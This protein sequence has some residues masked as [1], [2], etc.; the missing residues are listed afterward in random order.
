VYRV[1]LHDVPDDNDWFM[2]STT[3][4]AQMGKKRRSPTPIHARCRRLKAQHGIAPDQLER[5]SLR[6]DWL[7][8]LFMQPNRRMPHLSRLDLS[9]KR[10]VRRLLG[11]ANAHPSSPSTPADWPLR[12]VSTTHPSRPPPTSMSLSSPPKSA[13]PTTAWTNWGGTVS[14]PATTPDYR[15]MAIV[16]LGVCLAALGL[17][18]VYVTFNP[19]RP[20]QS[21]ELTIQGVCI[22]IPWSV[23]G[24]VRS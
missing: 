3:C 18:V 8:S 20:F 9:N 13:S 22:G 16:I 1:L 24:S 14:T 6:P 23:D 7:S 4:L 12:S 11:G 5:L 2:P 21:S 15:I 10:S 17:L 19:P